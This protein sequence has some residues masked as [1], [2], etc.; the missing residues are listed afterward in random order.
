MNASD[1]RLIVQYVWIPIRMC[2]VIVTAI[3]LG[4]FRGAMRS[5]A[6]NVR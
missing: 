6:H 4:G 3:F 2:L 5:K 1:V